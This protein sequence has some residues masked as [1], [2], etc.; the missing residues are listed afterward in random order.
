M[1]K[2]Y[3]ILT[4]NGFKEVEGKPVKIEGF[5]WLDL[6]AHKNGSA[7]WMISEGKTGLGVISWPAST[8]KEAKKEAE[9]VLKEAGKETTGEKIKNSVFFNGISPRYQKDDPQKEK[10]QESGNGTIFKKV[11]DCLIAKLRE[12]A[13]GERSL[14]YSEGAVGITSLLS[15]PLKAELR[16]KY[17]D[18]RTEALEIDDG[19]LFEREVKDSLKTLYPKRVKDEFT[20][21]YHAKDV[22]IEGH[23]DVVIE[24]KGK[25]LALELKH[26]RFLYHNL[27]NEPE[28]IVSGDDAYRVAVPEHYITQAAIQKALLQ[29]QFQ[30]KEVVHYL[31]IKSMISLNGRGFK[32]TYVIRETKEGFPVEKLETLIDQFLNDKSPRYSWECEYC[33]YR[34]AGVCETRPWNGE[35][36]KLENG[37][38]ELPEHVREAYQELQQ[39][40]VREKD[41]V[42]Y[43]KKELSGKCFSVNGNGKLVGW[44]T[45]TSY[46]WDKNMLLKELGSRFPDFVQIDWR[47]C[48]LLEDTLGERMEE[49]RKA[50]KKAEFR[51]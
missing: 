39:L 1:Q 50:E 33:I 7:G 42:G 13:R 47:K 43:L 5:E 36:E 22:K 16:K 21:T 15:C 49:F 23:V 2:E 8:L 38:D 34:E 18:L 27:Q 45:R 37:L 26:T 46:Q 24:G 19:F 41:L 14:S 40:R 44:I 31:F 17:P 51:I 28:E 11:F 10:R 29:K 30:N 12:Q 4:G 3:Y 48:Q 20:V 9:R 35:T 6:F 32:K 25:V